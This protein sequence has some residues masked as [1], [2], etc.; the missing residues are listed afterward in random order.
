MRK[1][2]HKIS[3][4]L[5]VMLKSWL[6]DMEGAWCCL[7]LLPVVSLLVRSQSCPESNMSEVIPSV[8][9]PFEGQTAQTLHGHNS[10]KLTG[11]I[12]QV[13]GCSYKRQIR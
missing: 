2:K 10:S 3:K 8:P 11:L 12:F 5:A 1:F 13:S 7:L 9:P 4:I 6:L